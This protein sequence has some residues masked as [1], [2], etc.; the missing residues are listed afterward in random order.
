[1]GRARVTILRS[2]AITQ[3][4]ALDSEQRARR[5]RRRVERA[6]RQGRVNRRRVE[7]MGTIS[8]ARRTMYIRDLKE[9]LTACL[10]NGLREEHVRDFRRFV[11]V[12]FRRGAP[13]DPQAAMLPSPSLQIVIRQVALAFPSLS[14]Y[15]GDC[16]LWLSDPFIRSGGAPIRGPAKNPKAFTE[17]WIPFNLTL[18]APAGTHYHAFNKVGATREWGDD[19]GEAA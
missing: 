1:M 8:Q 2:D 17:H 4:D 3:E 19:P 14:E 10:R 15:H 6:Y 18:Y 7:A 9:M 16:R 12:W 11:L 5:F 13:I